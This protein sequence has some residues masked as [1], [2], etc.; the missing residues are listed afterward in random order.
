MKEKFESINKDFYN[1]IS[2]IYLEPTKINKYLRKHSNVI[3]NS[4][5]K[6]FKDLNLHENFAIYANGGFGRKEMFPTSDVDISIVEIK[7][8]KRNKIMEKSMITTQS[9]ETII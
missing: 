6:K 7:K 5:K 8:N 3:E 9:L 2:D 1:N 4:I